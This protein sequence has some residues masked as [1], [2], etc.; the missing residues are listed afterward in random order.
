MYA[1][2][3]CLIFILWVRARDKQWNFRVFGKEAEMVDIHI[4]TTFRPDFLLRR[5]RVIDNSC[6]AE[7]LNFNLLFSDSVPGINFEMCNWHLL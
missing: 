6:N 5:A 1:N 7:F 3:G 2:R 4:N